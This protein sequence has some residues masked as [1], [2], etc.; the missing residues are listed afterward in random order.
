[1]N[2]V[3]LNI[4]TVS[5]DSVLSLSVILIFLSE[6]V[7]RVTSQL[8]QNS[9]VYGIYI[10]ITIIILINIIIQLAK[11]DVRLFCLSECIFFTFCAVSFLRGH[12][13][14]SNLLDTAVTAL[15]VCIPA[16]SAFVAIDDKRVLLSWFRSVSPFWALALSCAIV[17]LHNESSYS[18]GSAM[19]L[20][21][22]VILPVLFLVQEVLSGLR[23]F[24]FCSLVITLVVLIAF[25]SRGPLLS[26]AFLLLAESVKKIRGGNARPAAMMV[27]FTVAGFF[28]LGNL[29]AILIPILDFLRENN[30]Y[31]SRNIYYLVNGISFDLSD[32]GGIWAE[33]LDLFSRNPLYGWGINS[34]EKLIGVNP[35]NTVLEMAVSCG[36]V[37]LIPY[38]LLL[39][40]GIA[41]SLTFTDSRNSS[42]QFLEIFAAYSLPFLLIRSYLFTTT[43]LYLF[44][45]ASAICMKRRNN[46]EVGE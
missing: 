17:L 39:V 13:D 6:S 36:A 31:Y 40:S 35:H 38:I 19:V 4:D 44:L 29:D 42:E 1:M 2:S 26:V 24:P 11:S 32:R 25:G 20:S 41:Q 14:V 23:I 27:L 9:A 46:K 18:D 21:Y 34:S 7:F 10:I 30:I 16:A 3:S 43:G 37:G 15:S 33:A 45:A 12:S 5:R 8:I 22:C 28:V